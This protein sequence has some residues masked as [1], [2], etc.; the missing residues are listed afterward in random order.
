V[1]LGFCTEF[2]THRANTLALASGSVNNPII[3]PFLVPFFDSTPLPLLGYALFG[4]AL[5]LAFSV[6]TRR[7]VI[8]MGLSFVIFLATRIV[9]ASAARPHYATP[10]RTTAPLGGHQ[11]LQMPHGALPAGFSYLDTTGTP[12]GVPAACRP[13]QSTSCLRAHGIIARSEAYQPPGRLVLQG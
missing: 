13:D 9:L 11:P 7:T 3:N 10:L 4:F 6:L 2:L 5:G 12:V 1:A 8:S